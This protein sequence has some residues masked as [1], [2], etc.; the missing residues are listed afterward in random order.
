VGDDDY[1]FWGIEYF[2]KCFEQLLIHV[3]KYTKIC[4][5]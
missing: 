5:L 4:S 3:F 2:L 1:F